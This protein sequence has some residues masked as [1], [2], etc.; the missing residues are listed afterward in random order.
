MTDRHQITQESIIF[1]GAICIMNPMFDIRNHVQYAEHMRGYVPKARYAQVLLAF[2]R[3]Q[4]VY[5]PRQCPACPTCPPVK[6]CP[7]IP[8]CPPV[9]A[10]P[11]IKSARPAPI[12]A[13]PDYPALVAKFEKKIAEAWRSVKELPTVP[14]PYELR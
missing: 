1:L 10:C 13:H 3:Y 2:K 14:E 5:P 6:A 7:P 8:T 4:T 12:E 11:P 9:K